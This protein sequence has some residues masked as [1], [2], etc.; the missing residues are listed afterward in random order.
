MTDHANDEAEEIEAV[1]PE[2]PAR[3]VIDDE[4]ENLPGPSEPA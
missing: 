1:D 4:T 3:A 2:S